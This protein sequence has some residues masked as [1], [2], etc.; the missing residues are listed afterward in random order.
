MLSIRHE[1]TLITRIFERV[2]RE[3]ERVPD[4]RGARRKTRG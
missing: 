2:I 1:K 4:F 3:T